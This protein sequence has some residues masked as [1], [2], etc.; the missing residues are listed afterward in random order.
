MLGGWVN[1]VVN[2]RSETLL[3]SGPWHLWLRKVYISSDE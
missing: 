1:A 3:L 2:V